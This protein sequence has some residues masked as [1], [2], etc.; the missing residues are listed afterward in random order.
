MRR[1]GFTLV[2][3]L[4]TIAIMGVITG[5]SVPMYRKYEERSCVQL[6]AENVAQAVGR[7]RLLSQSVEG[8]SGWGYSV[9]HGV[10]FK[11]SSY[12]NRDPTFDETYSIGDCAKLSGL[13]EVAFRKLTGEPVVAGTIT[14]A[15]GD[16]SANIDVDDD[17]GSVSTDDDDLV[18]CHYPPGNPT[19]KH[20]I[21][22]SD[23]A[24]PAHQK[25]GDTIGA[26]PGGSVF[27]VASSVSSAASSTGGGGGGGS[28]SFGTCQDR[29]SVAANG[30]ITATGPVSATFQVLGSQITYGARGPEINVYVSTSTNGGTSWKGLYGGADVDGGE[31]QTLTGL[32]SGTRIL[33]RAR[34]YY[35]SWF[36]TRFDQTYSTPDATGHLVVLRDGQSPPSY[37]AFSNQSSLAVFLDNILDAQGKIDIGP[38]DAVVIGEL[39]VNNLHSNSSAVDFQDI[40]ILVTFTMEGSC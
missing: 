3:G 22:V 7:A 19:N 24:W 40:V 26:C 15:D 8:D 11:G 20:T 32:V 28:S 17:S 18:I 1:T 27:S 36:R 29:F 14:V 2:E 13:S 10:L 38:Y 16:A 12:A 6:A 23:N 30:T 39:G 35:T 33:V 31:Q 5:V 4:L 25:H 9:E 34:G 21:S 37:P